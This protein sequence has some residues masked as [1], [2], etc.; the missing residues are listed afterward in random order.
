VEVIGWLYQY[1]ISERKDEVFEALKQNQKIEAEDIPAATQLFTPHW[2]VRYLVENSLGRLWMLNHPNSRLRERMEYYI[3]PAQEETDFLR[4]ASPEELRLLD[5]AC[6]S[7][8]I[9]TYAFDLLYAIYEEEGYASNDIPRLILERN[10][11]GVEIDGR[12]GA[13]AAFALT[14]KAR[15]K[16]RRFFSRSVL[17]NIC[18]LENVTFNESELKQYMNAVGRDLFTE[19]L[20]ETLKQF[21]QAENFGSLIRPILTDA[22]YVRGLLEEKNM[23][24]DMFYS[25]THK[26][27]LKVLKFA[28]FLAPRYHA[29]VANP[30]YMGSS[31]MNEDIKRFALDCYPETKSDLFAMFIERNL[32]LAVKDGLVGMITMQSWMFLSSHEKLRMKLLE[33]ETILSMAH[34]GARAF[35]TIGGEIVSTTAF[36]IQHK[37]NP[38]F[39]GSYIRLIDGS[40]EAQKA[41]LFKSRIPTTNQSSPSNYYAVSAAEFK[42]IPGAPIAYWLS[43]NARKPFQKGTF[44]GDIATTRVGMATGDNDRF[45]RLWS[46]VSFEKI[47]FD[48]TR[49]QAAKSRMKWFPYSNGGEV[50][51]WYANYLHVVNWENDGYILQTEKHESGRIRAHNFNL[52]KIFEPGLTWSLINTSYS[53]I[54]VLPKGFLFSSGA[55]SLFSRSV[56]E[57]EVIN[58]YY[59]SVVTQYYLKAINPTI[60]NNSGDADKLPYYFTEQ[61]KRKAQATVRELIEISKNDWDSSEISWGFEVSPL[62]GVKPTNAIL[63]QIYSKLREYWKEITNRARGLEEENNS[64][65][66][67][68]Y[69]LE[70]E[71]SSDVALDEITLYCNPFNRYGNN[72]SEQELEDRLLADTMKEFISYAVGCMFGRYSLDKSGLVLANQGETLKDYL[73]KVCSEEWIVDSKGE[74]HD[75]GSQ[76][77]RVDRLAESNESGGNGLSGNQAISEGR[78]L[79]FDES[80]QAFGSVDSIEHSGRSS[81]KINGGISEFLVNCERFKSR[82]GDPNPACP[83][84]ELCNER[85]RAANSQPVGRSKQNAARVNE[86]SEITPH[87]PLST[88]HF[89]PDE[90]NAIPVLEGEWFND[91]IAERFKKFLRVTFG[92][93]H[94]EENLA[95]IEE[96]IGRDVRSYFVKEFYKDHVQT[97][98]KRPIYWMFSSPK[99]SFN[100]LIYMHRYQPDTVSIVLNGYLREYIK[101]LNAHKSQ[102]ER[103][104]VSGSAS[105]SQKTKALKEIQQVNKVLSELKEYEDEVLYPLATQRVSIDLDDGV[106][107]NYGKFGGALSPIKGL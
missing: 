99:G 14:M 69:G 105:Q 51:K 73:R 4:I 46:E 106:K 64:I 50:K 101:K 63:K 21:E 52:D 58:G 87:C 30:P 75:D 40:N 49:Q 19:P 97:Y 85:Y 31:G 18:V 42:K 17:P 8:H 37:K 25:E 86:Q 44:L 66:I 96:A 33:K 90:D 22:G 23:G 20:K 35:D 10:I 84:L 48:M 83:A 57:I 43:E 47:G 36:L 3:A 12:A 60:N 67:N 56:D 2:I 77:Q 39:K 1:Y 41:A 16:D 61:D 28:E 7:G 79:R 45:V 24:G 102:L 68:A 104:S 89:L 78:T 27:V 29:V 76:L 88:I 81:Q 80:N 98:K 32:D 59:N 9:L 15:A 70:K 92:E 93:E 82:D 34:L 103:T 72:T 107:V 95:F 53:A 100:V 65:F 6:G 54:R 71:L 38:K 55:P 91:D 26:S 13:L 74:N 11:F 62:V 94:Y 5:P